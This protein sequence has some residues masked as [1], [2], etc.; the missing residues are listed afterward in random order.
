MKATTNP[1]KNHKLILLKKVTQY[2]VKNRTH[3]DKINASKSTFIF[4][5]TALSDLKNTNEQPNDRIPTEKII[6]FFFE[7]FLFKISDI[8]NRKSKKTCRV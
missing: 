3:N 1:Q 8:R 2:P 7:A 6:M 4:S 5:K